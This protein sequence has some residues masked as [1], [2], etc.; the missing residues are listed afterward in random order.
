[1]KASP[2]KVLWGFGKLLPLLYRVVM[3]SRFIPTDEK[4]SL[5]RGI[6]NS[7]HQLEDAIKR[8]GG[9]LPP[10]PEQMKKW[11]D[12]VKKRRALVGL[13]PAG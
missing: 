10:T 4:E 7:Y 6:E 2:A 3:S 13:P 8:E 9:Q 11:D 1:M 12:A 5:Y